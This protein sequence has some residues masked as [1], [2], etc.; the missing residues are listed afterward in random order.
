[1]CVY[2]RC[3]FTATA[4]TTKKGNPEELESNEYNPHFMLNW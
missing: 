3:I 4:V 1:M 2:L